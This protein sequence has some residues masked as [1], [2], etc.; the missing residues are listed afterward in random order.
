MKACIGMVKLGP[1]GSERNPLVSEQ[2]PVKPGITQLSFLCKTEEVS[3]NKTMVTGTDIGN[4][5]APPADSRRGEWRS[6]VL[7]VLI[8]T[9]LLVALALMWTSRAIG[10][11][12]EGPRRVEIVLASATDDSEYF[13][14]ADL[15]EASEADSQASAASDAVPDDPP[16]ID[17]SEL[18]N[19]VAPIDLPLPGV[20]STEMTTPTQSAALPKA[21]LTDAQKQMLAAE[22][23]AFVARLPKGPPTSLRVFGSGELSGRKFVFVIDRS[24]SMGA[25]GLNVLNAATRELSTAIDGLENFHQ[26]QI[27]AYHH[28]TMTIE[29]RRLLN[30]TEQNKAQVPEFMNNLA[31]FGG[32][33]HE[34]A[35]NMALGMG[36]DVVMLLTDGGMPELNQA[37]LDRIR[38]AA[39]GAQIHCVQFGSGPLQQNTNFMRKLAG[40]NAG[41]YRYI[42]VTEWNR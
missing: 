38:R 36:P 24:R 8:H 13:D 7:S 35:L 5:P 41:T 6:V 30:A 29:Q 28:R 18:V 34:L 42:D 1:A 10:G 23:A 3:H 27:V 33:E 22:S 15:T 9:A 17:V 39:G 32:T 40:Q 11:G 37:Q 20:T 25:Q 26:F 4:E 16:P 2:C 19:E 21:E 31:A 12:D 14:E